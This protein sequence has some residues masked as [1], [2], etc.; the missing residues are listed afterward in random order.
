MFKLCRRI[1]VLKLLIMT[2]HYYFVAILFVLWKKAISE[3]KSYFT[4]E[5][6]LLFV[7][8]FDLNCSTETS[9]DGVYGTLIDTGGRHL[10]IHWSLHYDSEAILVNSFTF[11]W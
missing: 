2:V 9:F 1:L 3:N 11:Y 4:A 5:E 7:L 10:K 8:F 6:I